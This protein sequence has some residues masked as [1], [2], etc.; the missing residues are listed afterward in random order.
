MSRLS[1]KWKLRLL[2]AVALAAWI[3]V[4][5]FVARPMALEWVRDH[6]V[7]E[8]HVG[9]VVAWPWLAVDAF[10]VRLEHADGDDRHTLR[11]SRVTLSLDPIGLFEGA[12]V[13]SVQVD[14]LIATMSPG[15]SPNIFGY[16]GP[17]SDAATDDAGAAREKVSKRGRA[18]SFPTFAF[19][20]PRIRVRR[21]GKPDAWVFGA[22][23]LTLTRDEAHRYRLEAQSGVLMGF[24]FE[25]AYAD[26]RPRAG[27]ILIGGLKAHAFAGI[28]EGYLEFPADGE[29]VNGEFEW[30]SA[31]MREVGRHYG[32]ADAE[33]MGGRLQGKL[34]FAGPSLVPDLL[35]GKGWL[36]LKDG[37]FISP[38]SLKAAPLFKVPVDRESIFHTADVR[39]SFE[40]AVLH[41]E[42]ATVLGTSFD[43]KAQ[44]QIYFSGHLD[45]ELTHNTIT[46][47]ASGPLR[48]PDVRVLPF[49]FVTVPADRLTR[50]RQGAGR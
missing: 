36:K 4:S 11:A 24:P 39:F 18:G 10:G 13:G 8:P 37:K 1:R 29:F 20:G 21:D 43:F 15:A 6:Y 2:I 16:Q 40:D 49:N 30:H 34:S 44:G 46:V 7:G 33:R 17:H 14:G 32:L 9:L 12:P 27:S 28:M 26:L 25:Q 38:I 48:D 31:E 42:Q 22:E 3:G 47:A 19:H 41:V 35:R 45:L 50:G 23:D 5:T